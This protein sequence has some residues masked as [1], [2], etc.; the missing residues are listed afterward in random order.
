MRKLYVPLVFSFITSCGTQVNYLGTSYPET[1]VVDVFVNQ[2]AVKQPYEVIGKGYVERYVGLAPSVET[3]QRK[4]VKKAKLK[5]A[6]AVVIEDYFFIDK[7]S[8][9]TTRI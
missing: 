5:G 2:S 4:A 7:T 9:I 1:T 6:N 8:G 3:I